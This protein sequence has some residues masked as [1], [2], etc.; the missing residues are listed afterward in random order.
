MKPDKKSVM[1]NIPKNIKNGMSDIRNVEKI[2]A[3]EKIKLRC[4]CQHC[5]DSGH[6]MLFRSEN[7]KSDI[8]GNPL[9]CCRLCGAYIDIGEIA[10]D[11]LTR[12]IDTICRTANVIKMRLRPKQSE[13]DK[14]AYKLTWRIQYVLSNGK[15][16][17][18]YKAARRRGKNKQRRSGGD[19]GFTSGAPRSSGR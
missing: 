11:E 9:F 7:L 15:Y 10:D 18:L 6:T 14:E 12:S 5:D 8:T 13:D 3:K 1:G 17:D 4:K 19:F 16:V 2:T